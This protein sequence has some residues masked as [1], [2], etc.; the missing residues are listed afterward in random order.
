M[1]KICTFAG[2]NTPLDEIFKIDITGISFP[3][4]NYS[5]YRKKSNIFVFEYVYS[6]KGNIKINDFEFIPEKNDVYILPMGAEHN[7]FSDRKDPFHKIWFNVSGN[8]VSSLLSVYSLNGVH[9]IKNVSADI[10][11]LFTEFLET[12]EKYNRDAPAAFEKCSLVFMKIIQTLSKE[13]ASS[14]NNNLASEVKKLCDSSVYSKITVEKIS[15]TL[16]YSVAHLNRVF[17]KEFYCTIGN[18]IISNKINAAKSLLSS[19]SLNIAEIAYLL[20]FTDEHY[21]SN[22]FKKK[23][24]LSPK[25][26]RNQK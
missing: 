24:G 2:M 25:A 15:E 26:Y 1:E 23:T 14:S 8:L 13:N 12:A 9:I 7:Y 6:G 16:G 3:D 22:L 20:S 19:T 10:P 17:K 18:Y 5:V 21:F 11:T 4:P